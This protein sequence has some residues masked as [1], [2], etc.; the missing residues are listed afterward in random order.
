MFGI[1]GRTARA[2]NHHVER[3]EGDPFIELDEQARADSAGDS[4][5]LDGQHVVGIKLVLLAVSLVGMV[6]V[7]FAIALAVLR[8][9]VGP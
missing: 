1:Q 7:C 9:G 2:R 8:L 4:R 6:F 5:H 3:R